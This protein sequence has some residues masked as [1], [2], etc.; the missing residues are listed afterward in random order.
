MQG[1]YR[2]KQKKK[3]AWV[4]ALLLNTLLVVAEGRKR[5]WRVG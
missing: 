1:R 5:K 2:W 3:R 4:Q